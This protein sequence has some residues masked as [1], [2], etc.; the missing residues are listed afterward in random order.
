MCL[1]L[2]L[3]DEEKKKNPRKTWTK[4]WLLR[5]KEKSCYYNLMQELALEVS[6]FIYFLLKEILYY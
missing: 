1:T 3:L 4:S 6:E 5:R 2:L